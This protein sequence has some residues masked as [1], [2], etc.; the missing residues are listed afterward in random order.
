M[1]E[2][3]SLLSNI[4]KA[5]AIGILVVLVKLIPFERILGINAQ[6]GHGGVMPT[7]YF[8]PMIFIYGIVSL[9]LANIKSSLSIGRKGHLLLY[10]CFYSSSIRCCLSLKVIFL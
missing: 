10:L 6:T 5:I 3:K 8:I 2:S 9:E 4:I 7:I 1:L